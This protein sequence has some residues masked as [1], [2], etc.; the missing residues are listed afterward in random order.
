MHRPT[1]QRRS[2]RLLFEELERRLLLSADAA[3]ALLEPGALLDA[4]EPAE[5]ERLHANDEAAP[6]AVESRRELVFVDAGIAEREALLRDLES[7]GSRW[8][9]VV[10]LDGDRDGVLQ[11]AE[12]LGRHA[13]LD[14]VHVFS[15]GSAGGVRLGNGWLDAD[16]L[17]RHHAEVARWGDALAPGADLLF[18]G[19]DLAQGGAGAAFAASLAGLTGADVAASTD[20]T[21][22]A[23]LGG[24]WELEGRT[25]AVEAAAAVG[26]DASWTGVL[27]VEPALWL[28]TAGDVSGSGAAGLDAW[29]GGA[30]VQVGPADLSFGAGSTAGAFSS[31]FDL[32]PFA[33]TPGA[34]INA[35]HYV[36]RDLTL[37][38][39]FELREGDLLLSTPTNGQLTLTSSNSLSVKSRDVFVFRPD[40][41]GDYS[42]GSFLMLLEAPLPRDLT[43]L[44]LVEQDTL[45]G[46]VTLRQG[47][48]LFS[49]RAGNNDNQ[50]LLFRPT[51]MQGGALQGSIQLLLDG[52]DPGLGG[53]GAQIDG[54]E[55]VESNT[56]IGNVTLPAGTLLLG[57]ESATAVGSNGLP[58]AVHD[59]V[60]LEVTRTTLG[61]GAGN[62]QATASAFFEGSGVGL[63]SAAEAID[64]VAIVPVQVSDL[65]LTLPGQPLSYLENDPATP[66]APGV[67]LEPASGDFDGGSLLVEFLA[68]GTASDRLSIRSEGALGVSGNQLLYDFGSGAVVIGT[69]TGGGDGATPLVI[70]FGANADAESVEAVARNVTYQSVSEDPPQ[71]SRVL[72]FT[73]SEAGGE[74]ASATTPVHVSAVNDAPVLAVPGAQ[75]VPAGMPLVFST[76][77]GNLALVSDVDAASVEVTLQVGGGALSLGDTTGLVFSEGTGSADVRMTFRGTLPVVNA[78]LDGLR[79]DPAAGFDGPTSL[80]IQT[81]DLGQS[82]GG[83]ALAAAAVVAIE[84]TPTPEPPPEPPPL[85]EPP[86][87]PEPPA[88]EPPP[89]A[90]APAGSGDDPTDEPD[91]VGEDASGPTPPAG[92]GDVALSPPPE[93]S[94]PVRAPAG[95]LSDPASPRDEVPAPT[96]P[97]AGA[98]GEVGTP[99]PEVAEPHDED[100]AAGERER[101]RFSFGLSS[102]AASEALDAVRRDLQEEAERVSHEPGFGWTMARGVAVALSTS[103]LGA[104]LRGGSLLAM[105]LSSLPIWL[106]FDPLAILALTDAERERREREL[107]D[108]RRDEDKRGVGRVLDEVE[109][110]AE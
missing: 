16:T 91:E 101:P 45:L 97:A 106:R 2:P 44:T 85:P 28:S 107:R 86:P 27:G 12:V 17:P 100:A 72:R 57:F 69:F 37:G 19:C 24:D 61:S 46:D 52:E 98:V 38:G 47:D 87:P 15:H 109:A 8:L 50:V 92:P 43:A 78:A 1:P 71:A 20:P 63:D 108:A 39:G 73:V 103:V 31:R 55:L 62:G 42:S 88:P 59:I 14:A 80:S 82:G 26:A 67:A 99:A 48:L 32:D 105:T 6:A 83:G 11:I 56:L 21:G 84:V 41:A 49:A 58:V 29:S 40:S 64:A 65:K 33:D 30:A 9:E 60:R 13:E 70:A 75:S 22:S 95:Q 96:R 4:A 89:P 18:Y 104:L 25:G 35:L 66:I 77:N 94:G 5:L 110:P 36:S 102:P 81:S 34:G 23:A 90:E 3:L 93:P 74:S 76:A 10:V 7:A 68:N 51:G 54:L 53:F 79:F